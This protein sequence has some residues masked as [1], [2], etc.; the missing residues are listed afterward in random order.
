MQTEQRVL[1]LQHGV[2]HLEGGVDLFTNFGT[3]QD[4][5]P[6]DEDQENDLRLDHAI[7]EAREK[8]RLV[9]AEVMMATRQ[10]LQTNW[11]LDVAGA[12][13]VLDLEVRELCVEAELLN[14]TRVLA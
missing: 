2:D 10:T 1:T 9:R 11:E 12:N 3:G 14:D 13:N 6:T 5:L 8:F 7:D 4:D